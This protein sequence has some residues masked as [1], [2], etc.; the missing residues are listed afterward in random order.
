MSILDC[1]EWDAFV[2]CF[3]YY[4]VTPVPAYAYNPASA[5]D[6]S[7]FSFI[8]DLTSQ[9]VIADEAF[10][11]SLDH[12][13]GL[14]RLTTSSDFVIT[15]RRGGIHAISRFP[16]L[17]PEVVG[18]SDFALSVNE[19]FEGRCADAKGMPIPYD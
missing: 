7:H 15:T 5:D 12:N 17:D 13:V 14:A 11:N 2:G 8:K 3:F 10:V 19:N 6:S 18:G 9:P 1:H 16:R 4:F